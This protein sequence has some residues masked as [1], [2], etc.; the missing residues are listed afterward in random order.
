[1]SMRSVWLRAQQGGEI[2]FILLGPASVRAVHAHLS[3]FLEVNEN[4]R[5]K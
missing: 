4:I 2:A 1:M 5:V 3:A